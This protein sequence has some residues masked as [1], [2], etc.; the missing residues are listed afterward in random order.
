MAMA[1]CKREEERE[2]GDKEER[3]SVGGL[4][5]HGG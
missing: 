2:E 1:G 5:A 3:G 4:M